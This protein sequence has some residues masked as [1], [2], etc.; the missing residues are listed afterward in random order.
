VETDWKAVEA[1]L[2]RLMGQFA[3]FESTEV[4]KYLKT[5]QEVLRKMCSEECAEAA[6]LMQQEALYLQLLLNELKTKMDWAARQRDRIVAPQMKQY[7]KF[8]GVANIRTMAINQDSA[9]QEY[10]K[11]YCR[12]E[13]LHSR[14]N[15]IP[16]QLNKMSEMMSQYQRTKDR[17]NYV[18]AT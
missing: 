18:N 10:H 6:Y 16:T 8:L 2:N 5:S 11:I 17:Q 13:S 1:E 12:A 14:L 3:H 7:D 4:I 15:Y 9:A